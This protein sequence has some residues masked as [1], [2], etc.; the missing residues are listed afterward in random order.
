MKNL[1]PMDNKAGAIITT[2]NNLQFVPK[3]KY[4]IPINIP[5]MLSTINANHN[6][7]VLFSGGA[8]SCN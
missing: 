8:I 7:C 2:K 1:K 5:P 4:N 3:K 6:I